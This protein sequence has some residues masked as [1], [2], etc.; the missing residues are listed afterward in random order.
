MVDYYYLRFH[1]F[2]V[3]MCIPVMPEPVEVLAEGGG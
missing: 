2:D 3:W 1:R